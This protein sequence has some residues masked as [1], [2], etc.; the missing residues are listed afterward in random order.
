MKKILFFTYFFVVFGV[1]SDFNVF[2]GGSN[3]NAL[4][5]ALV[6]NIA[7]MGMI[8]VLVKIF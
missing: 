3:L 6:D 2:L 4:I 5:F 8:F 1:D 7:C